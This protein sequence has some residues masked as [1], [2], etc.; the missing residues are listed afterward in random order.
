MAEDTIRIGDRLLVD[1]AELTVT[2][3]RLPCYKLGIRFE[4]DDMVRRFLESRR[5]GFYAAVIREGEVGTGDEMI[6]LRD[7]VDSISVSEITRLYIA[8]S[9]GAEDAHLVRRAIG[10]RALPESWKIWLEQ[11]LSRLGARLGSFPTAA[12]MPPV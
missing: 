6:L 3:P 5:T 7:G 2:Q 8:K 4:F 11:K 10:T 12:R 9:Y 1:S